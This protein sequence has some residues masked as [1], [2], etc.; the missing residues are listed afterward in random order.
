MFTAVFSDHSPPRRVGSDLSPAPLA[1]K[2]V[3]N[4]S[5]SPPPL[6]RFVALLAIALAFLSSCGDDRPTVADWRP[7]WDQVSGAIPNREA[8]GESPPRDLCFEVL[9]FLRTNRA[10]LF[11]TP[12]LAIDDAVNLWVEIAEDAFFGCP[13][14][15]KSVGSFADA[16]DEM[17]RLQRE[18]DVVLEMVGQS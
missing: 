6:R 10:N 1:W 2:A 17:F 7:T 18:I 13:P 14:N 4:P 8:V 5:G 15:N 9:A 11:P 16:Y 3:P 12:D